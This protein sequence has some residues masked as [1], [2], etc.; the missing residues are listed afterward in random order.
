VCIQP[1]KCVHPSYEICASDLQKVFIRPTKVVHSTYK[2]CAS[3]LI[4][5]C[6][7]PTKT[8][9]P[10]YK[11]CVHLTNKFVCNGNLTTNSLWLHCQLLTDKICSSCV[12]RINK[13]EYIRPTVVVGSMLQTTKNALERINVKFSSFH[14]K[15]DNFLILAY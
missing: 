12:G 11:K 9:F 3:D 1:K 6:I 7:R 14:M 8:V 2:G 10:T 4:K 5:V 15:N 13:I